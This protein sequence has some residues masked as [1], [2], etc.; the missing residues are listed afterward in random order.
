MET[1]E[2]RAMNRVTTLETENHAMR[3]LLQKIYPAVNINGLDLT[4][5]EVALMVGI[6]YPKDGKLNTQPVN[7]DEK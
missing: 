5:K 7:K 3:T 1:T 6:I 2:P 4:A